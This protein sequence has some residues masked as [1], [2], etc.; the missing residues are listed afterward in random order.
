MKHQDN[1]LGKR[2]KRGLFKSSTGR[3][4]NADVNGSLGILLKSKHKIDLVQLVNSGR[5]NRPRRV[6]LQEIVKNSSINVL[7]ELES[8]SLKHNVKIVND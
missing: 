4:I 6:M 1:Y 2:V 7:K 5:I 8:V 3:L